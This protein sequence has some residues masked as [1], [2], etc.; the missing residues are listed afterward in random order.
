[1]EISAA[2]SI[3]QV[4]ISVN[5]SPFFKNA[6]VTSIKIDMTPGGH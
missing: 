5:R 6:N 1:M 3:N 4:H 2:A